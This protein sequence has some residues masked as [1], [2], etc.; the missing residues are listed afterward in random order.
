MS[1]VKRYGIVTVYTYVRLGY[2]VREI[3]LCTV[4]CVWGKEI[5]KCYCEH[6]CETELHCEG[7][8]TVYSDVP[9]V[10]REGKVNVYTYVCLSYR[11]REMIVC[12]VMCV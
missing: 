4:M 5:W 1:G 2:K 9:V 6:L 3:L 8:V 7:N 11:L 12:T 10:Q